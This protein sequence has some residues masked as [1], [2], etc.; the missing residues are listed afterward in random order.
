MPLYR[1]TP[2]GELVE[3]DSVRREGIHLVL[4]GTKLIIGQPREV[5]LRRLPSSVT[6]ELVDDGKDVGPLVAPPRG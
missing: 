3:A 1:L 5:V 2:P 4:R 6:V